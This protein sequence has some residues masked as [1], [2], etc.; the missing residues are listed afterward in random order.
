MEKV[1]CAD[2]PCKNSASCADQVNTFFG[3]SCSC[4]P[5]WTGLNC[6]QSVSATVQ[7]AAEPINKQQP[8]QANDNQYEN[9]VLRPLKDLFNPSKNGKD[10]RPN[11]Y[12]S[13]LSPLNYNNNQQ[14]GN[15]GLGATQ[16]GAV[17]QYG[18]YQY[19]N[20]Q[21]GINN[22]QYSNNNQYPNQYGYYPGYQ[23]EQMNS[24][25]YFISNKKPYDPNWNSPFYK[26]QYPNQQFPGQQYGLVLDRY[27]HD[28]NK[29]FKQPYA[30]LNNQLPANNQYGYG[31]NIYM[32][33]NGCGSSPCY[34]EGVS[35][36]I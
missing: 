15:T 6:D 24:L 20:N 16:Y 35:F 19:E 1:R 14:F 36:L 3:Y 31:G 28:P 22:Q 26:P 17:K 23:N 4:L 7:P 18:N 9:G 12:D 11:Y 25:N 30:E 8:R 32:A 13:T 5:N 27:P 34:N 21:Y 29:P 2:R 10:Y 33:Q